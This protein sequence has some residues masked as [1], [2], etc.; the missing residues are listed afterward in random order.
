M[1]NQKQRNIRP[2]RKLLTCALASCLMLGVAPAAFAQSTG[3]TL[4]GQV[5][6]DSAPAADAKVTAT[7]LAT[8]LTRSV[9]ANA[10]GGYSLAGLPPGTYRIDVAA[11]GKTSSQTVILQVGQT[12]TLNL[13]VGGVA[14]T[15]VGEATNLDTVTVTAPM[16]VETK[17]SEVATYVTQKQ[18]NALPQNSRNFLA[19]ADTVPGMQFVSSPNGQESQLRSGAQGASAI[20]VFIDGVGQKNYVTPGGITGQDDS[21]GNPFPQS[22]IGE[23][24]VITSNYKAE[25]DQ[26]GSAAVTAV[27]KSGTNDFN[28]S[29]FWDR[30]GDDWRKPTVEEEKRGSKTEE[31]TEQYGVSF[32]GPI[33]RDQLHFFV[34]YEAK[35]ILTPRDVKPPTVF[36]PSVLPADLQALYGPANAPFKQNLYFGKLSWQANDSNLVELSMR[37]RDESSITGV[38][39]ENS[40]GFGTDFVNDETRVDLRYQF[41]SMNWLND[42]H[43]TYEEAAYN[44]VPTTKAPGYRYTIVDP[45]NPGNRRL[46]VLNIGGSNNFQDKGQKGWAF[47]DDLTYF[48]WESHT[49]KMGVKYK[50]VDLKAFQQFPP[51]PQYFFDVNESL[52]RPYR[53]EYTTTL[54]GRDPFVESSN[55][56]F[57]IYL[58]DDWEV[59]DKL[60]LNLGVRWD[61]E[62]NPSYLDHRISDELLTALQGWANIQNTDYDVNDYIPNG[63]DRK[64]F[65]NA[66]QPRVGFSYDLFADQRHVIFGGAGRAYDRN[67]FD[68]MAREYYS[69]AFTTYGLDFDSPLHPCGSGCTAFSPALLTP[70]GLAAYAAANPRVGGEVQLLNNELKTPYSDQFS[71]GMRNSVSL[72]GQ[73]WN[74]S[75]A[76]SHIRS[77]DGIY[78]R[79]GNRYSDGRYYNVPGATWGGQPW[80]ESIPGYGSLILGDNGIDYNLNSLL[81][82]IDKPYTEASGWGI[83]LAYTYSDAEENNSNAA[84]GDENFV[85][86]YPTIPSR[87]LLSTGVPEHRL[88]LSGIY[89]AIWDITLSG[90]LTLASHRPRYA[91]NCRDAVDWNNCFFDPFVP[92]GSIGYKQFDLAAEK[93]WST[94]TDVKL[95]VRADMLNVFNWRNWNQFTDWRGGVGEALN[96]NFAERSGDEILLP[97]RTFKLSFGLDW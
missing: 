69:G 34:S 1:K 72:W 62:E 8:G 55:K 52:D 15:A 5:S 93:V 29:F 53:V 28:G 71:L 75:V 64:S 85:G 60:T 9:Q 16:L 70:E 86:D 26:I 59:N 45:G 4:R 88:V 74:T 77:R 18:I 14:E 21:R 33:I 41:S 82:S 63:N 56:Q 3:A 32:G 37:Y 20:N 61:Y 42:A 19:F 43:L 78:F 94:G 24:K 81:V 22:A 35:D 84:Q 97:T 6:A 89:D 31:S 49:I 46:S 58:Q 92:K 39:N 47:Q 2:T 27:S 91:I 11:A 90:K 50:Q 23:Y 40:V 73:D 7:N 38:G 51:Y 66:W 10:S 67:L 83:N 54:V 68:Y 48:G 65:K 95:R 17:T 44:P 96:P 13:G 25:Y 76:I 87:M 79:L 57:G 30:T 36:D 12:A 80:G